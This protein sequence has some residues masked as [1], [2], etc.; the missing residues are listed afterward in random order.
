MKKISIILPYPDEILKNKMETMVSKMPGGC[1]VS[2]DSQPGSHKYSF[3][4][5]NGGWDRYKRF[6]LQ[7]VTEEKL[8]DARIEMKHEERGKGVVY[9]CRLPGVM[10]VV[11]ESKNLTYVGE[12]RFK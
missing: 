4:I 11:Y 2:H 3:E 6:A 7:Y 12:M 9:T 10:D 8:V 5:M 1:N